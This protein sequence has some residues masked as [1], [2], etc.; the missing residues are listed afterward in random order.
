M[1]HYDTAEQGSTEW[2]ESR[3]GLITASNASK[4]M[5]TSQTRDTYL[6]QLAAERLGGPDAMESSFSTDWMRR[7]N[8]LEPQARAA[9]EFEKVLTVDEVGLAT[10]DD[11]PGCG[12]SLDGLIGTDMA[13]EIK[14]PKPG[15]LQRYRHTGK[16]PGNYRDQITFQMLICDLEAVHFWAWHPACLT[17]DKFQPFHLY[18]ERDPKACKVMAEKIREANALI[19]KYMK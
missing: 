6:Y 12:A 8:E 16:L 3:C 2:L 15:T 11:Y 17:S 9:F 5:G 1:I 13:V 10:N 18:I 4:I 7:G 14:A 19:E